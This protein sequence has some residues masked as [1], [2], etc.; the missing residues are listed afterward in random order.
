MGTTTFQRMALSH[1][2]IALMAFFLLATIL[3]G[4][5]GI[6]QLRQV[7]GAQ[8]EM[9]RGSVV[10]LR[11]VVDGGRQAAVHFRRMYPYILKTDAKSHAE[12]IDLNDKSEA[13]VLKAIAFLRDE[14]PT[15]GLRE[16]GTKLTAAWSTYKGSVTKLEAA[17]D[18]GNPD[19]GM[20]ELIANTDSMHVQV[21]N[22]LVEAGKQQ[23]AYA[24]AS[25]ETVARSVDSTAYTIM[26]IICATLVLGGAL[27]VAVIRSVQ[28]QL[29]G[30]P[31]Q[32]TAIAKRIAEGNLRV[33]TQ[34][35]AVDQ[36]SLMFHLWA[37]RSQLASIIQQ[38]RQSAESVSTASQEISAG[39]NDLSARTEQQ[40][41]AL[42]QTSA[43]MEELGTTSHQNT[44][45]ARTANQLAMNAS[46][47]AVQ[48]GE[49][50]AEVVQ[51]MKGI[52]ESSAKIADIIGVI[53]G[54]AFQTNILALNAAVEAAR[55]GEQG[56]GFAVV[57]SEVRALAQRSAAAAKEIKTLIS[58]SSERV[59]HGS[60][61]VD[62]AGSTMADMVSAIRRVTDIVGEISAASGEQNA[63]IDQVR[64]AVT[65]MDTATQQ[66]AALVEESAA[67]AESLKIQAVQLVQ[68]VSVFSLDSAVAQ[69]KAP[70][71]A[72][73][74][75]A[76]TPI[77][78]AAP[79]ARAASRPAAPSAA[80]K[81]VSAPVA[82]KA[83]VP[84]PAM[85]SAS[86]EAGSDWESF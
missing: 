23:E 17:V 10:P 83:I 40:A 13:D 59:A 42:E 28:K 71:P 57:A 51:T 21:R 3:T 82:A 26:L 86:Q 74:H 12:T 58:A 2:L 76:N 53:D 44:D 56:R 5:T 18:A 6:Y 49:V 36:G 75:F 52:N 54:I 37:M 47:V 72:S 68:A 9:Y 48:G 38:V 14:A 69:P 20:Q 31:V 61:L 66:N 7:S 8:R 19:A 27:G 78:P 24:S 33:D 73:H 22:L 84:A 50:V 11:T 4:V 1:K 81:P 60:A 16:L 79:P 77:K 39:T 25:T 67:A 55:A 34:L 35:E 15:P 29:G 45:S 65:Q 41:S 85:A 30:D 43:S 70:A 46:S 64:Q 63:G 62:K 80:R 32:A